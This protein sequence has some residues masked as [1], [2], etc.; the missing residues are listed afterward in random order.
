MYFLV[1]FYIKIIIEISTYTQ[2]DNTKNVLYI[3][4]REKDF[5]N[6]STSCEYFVEYKFKKQPFSIWLNYMAH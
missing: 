1:I 2:K 3:T 5:L 4:P 6:H